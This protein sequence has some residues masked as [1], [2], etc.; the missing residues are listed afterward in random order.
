MINVVFNHEK[1]QP[2]LADLYTLTGI[3]PS[4]H[5]ISGE[6]IGIRNAQAEFC[7]LMNALPEG[8]ERCVKCDAEAARKCRENRSIYE[9]R[10]HAGICE[11][12]VPIYDNGAIIAFLGFGQHLDES[13]LKKQWEGTRSLLSW[14]PGG[15]DEL[16][17]AFWQLRKIPHEQSQALAR[18]LQ[19]LGQQIRTGGAVTSASPTD[20]QRLEQYLTEN[21]AQKIPL[22]QICADLHIGTTRLCAIAKEISGG[23]TLTWM[24]ARIRVAEAEKLLL[25]TNR[26]VSEIALLCGYEDYNY[27]TKV[28]RRHTGQTP[29]RYRRTKSTAAGS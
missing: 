8:H 20:G 14:Y 1:L 7:R 26:P 17:G 3:R 23:H 6:D 4:I 28:F 21:Y 10:C 16:R 2:I 15:P 24:L 22:A 13:P 27:F 18:I 11:T 19:S 29:L 25:S 5:K 12:L 9:Y